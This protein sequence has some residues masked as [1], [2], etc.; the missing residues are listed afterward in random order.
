[1]LLVLG[2]SPP[3]L[4]VTLSEG[5]AGPAA[6]PR[7]TSPSLRS[8]VGREKD[9]QCHRSLQSYRSS[10]SKAQDG[11]DQDLAGEP[12]TQGSAGAGGAAVS[13]SPR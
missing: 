8:L 9:P 2:C 13:R 11:G 5:P 4:R 1:M 10:A 6:A 12:H 7:Q 3:P